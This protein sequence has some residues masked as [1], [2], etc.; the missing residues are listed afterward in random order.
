MKFSKEYRSK[1]I[2]QK[3]LRERLLCS[4]CESKFAVYERYAAEI[5]YAKNHRSPVRN[6][7][8]SS[9]GTYGLNKFVGFDY[10]VFKL[11][12]QSILWR[13]AISSSFGKTSLDDDQQNI[14][15]KSLYDEAPLNENDFGCMVQVIQQKDGTPFNGSIISPYP[16][17][18]SGYSFIN[19]LMDGFLLTFFTGT[20]LEY[21]PFNKTVLQKDGSM[22][23]V[24]RYIG[25]DE[26]LMTIIS[27]M[28][29]NFE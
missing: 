12:L 11:F 4:E 13:L 16:V 29:N 22:L 7:G 25:V 9:N 8:K 10:T 21:T 27:S 23:I 28:I 5:F 15:R 19:V 18:I 17:E 1:R 6:T 24:E 26:N 20:G 14:L 2:E 3:G